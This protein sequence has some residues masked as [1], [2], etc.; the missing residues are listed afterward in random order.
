M[1][2]EEARYCEASSPLIG[3]CM[4][5]CQLLVCICAYR[6]YAYTKFGVMK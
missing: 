5:I 3:F 1:R 2:G 6:L 4:L